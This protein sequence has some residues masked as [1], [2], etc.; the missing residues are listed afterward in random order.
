MSAQEGCAHRVGAA[1]TGI[2]GLT[3]SDLNKE[4][5]NETEQADARV[6]CFTPSRPDGDAFYLYDKIDS[7]ATARPRP[8]C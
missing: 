3:I 6:R 7:F 8:L 5:T 1:V 4:D 2:A